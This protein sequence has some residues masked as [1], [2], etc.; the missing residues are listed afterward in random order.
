MSKGTTVFVVIAFIVSNASTALFVLSL[1]DDAPPRLDL[2]VSTEIASLAKEVAALATKLEAHGTDGRVK[3]V[4]PGGRIGASAVLSR[5]ESIEAAIDRQAEA[6]D[7]RAALKLRETHEERF[8]AED[9]AVFAEELLAEKKFA[10]G[11]HGILSFLEAHPDHPDRQDLLRRARDGFQ[12]QG[13]L[14]RALELQKEIM[15]QYPEHR[16]SDLHIIARLERRMRKFEESRAHLDESIQ[17]AATDKERM[18]RLYYRAEL[19][20]EIDGDASGAEAYRDVQRQA[21]AVGYGP[22]IHN[23][24]K[25]A[26]RIESRLDRQK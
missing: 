12:N 22:V 9:G 2:A 8:R 4:T 15:E 11:A 25:R 1:Q 16:G 21:S 13:Y 14:D 23:A 18:D 7:Y 20:H 17:L 5:L 3:D 24:R 10:L 26:E 19:I 6:E